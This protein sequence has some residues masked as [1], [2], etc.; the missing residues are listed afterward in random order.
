[1]AFGVMGA[2]MQ[3]QGHVQFTMSFVDD[4]CS[5]QQSSDAPRWRIND[6]GQLIV[7]AHMPSEVVEGLRKLGHEP[8]VMPADSLEFGSAQA[9]AC[10]GSLQQGY[11][12]GSDHRRD[13]Q[14]VGF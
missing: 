13:G 5:P 12:S 4:R 6:N 11:L 3:A 1:M 10:L 7:E 2:N 14:A 8:Q 9:I